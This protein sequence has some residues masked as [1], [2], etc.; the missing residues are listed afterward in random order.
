MYVLLNHNTAI[1][2]WTSGKCVG[3][4]NRAMLLLRN[5]A[6]SRMSVSRVVSRCV[7]L[8]VQLVSRVYDTPVDVEIPGGVRCWRLLC[9]LG[10]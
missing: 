1:G 5:F 6:A 4:R 8:K 7:S 10:L 3:K 9:R 2:G